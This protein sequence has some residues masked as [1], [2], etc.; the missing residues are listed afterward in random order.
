MDA[1]SGVRNGKL[2]MLVDDDVESRRQARHL[3]ELRGMEV[4][5]ASNGMAALGLIQR[6]PDSFRLVV[7]EL[8]LP[9][10]SGAVLVGALR[11]FR[12][13]LP[14]LCI[15]GSRNDAGIPAVAGCLRKPLQ[16]SE[17][18]PAIKAVLGGGRTEWEPRFTEG[19]SESATARARA[20]F[21]VGND[22]VEAA[23]ELARVSERG[24]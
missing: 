11:L 4:V 20:R 5:Q 17:L 8:E 19:L 15:S 24:I 21:A 3:L 23:L 6:L 7:T 12:P 16:D 1:S 9:G 14:V 13:D 22:L 2:V 10:I 18:H